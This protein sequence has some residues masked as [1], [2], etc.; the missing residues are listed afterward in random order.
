MA[1][2]FIGIDPGV[3]GGIAVVDYYGHP[4]E[5]HKMPE[6][7]RD[8]LDVLEGYGAGRLVEGSSRAV[9]EKVNAG[10]FGARKFGQRMGVSSAFTFGQGIGRLTMA[11]TAS[12]IPFDQIAPATWQALLQCKTGGDKNISKRRA[13][14]LFPSL[15]VTHAIADALLL[16]EYCRRINR[17]SSSPRE[18]THGEEV[19][20]AVKQ[21]PTA[22]GAR[23]AGNVYEEPLTAK[24]IRERDR[25]ADSRW[26]DATQPAVA[27]AP[28]DGAG[29]KRKTR[30]VMRIVG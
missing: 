14:Q 11:L 29:P 24:E 27:A 13:Q 22:E 1:M 5:T 12:R 10:V 18:S 26:K 2:Y 28:R 17:S 9:L 16:A 7:E 20:E 25:Q 4:I 23:E 6:T 8:L 3:A 21:Q 30:S 15:K 19:K